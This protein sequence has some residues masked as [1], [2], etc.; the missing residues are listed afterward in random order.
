MVAKDHV[1][2]NCHVIANSTGIHVTKYGTSY[3]PEKLIADWEHDIC[4]LSFQYLNLEA[5][6]LGSSSD[7]DYG[8]NVIAK[9][10]VVMPPGR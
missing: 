9:V 1:V 8:T 3:P 10:M 2:T 5:V 6:T 7:V 4:I